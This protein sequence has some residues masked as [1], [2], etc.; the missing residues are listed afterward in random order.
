[1]ALCGNPTR[2]L[3]TRALGRKE[4][5]EWSIVDLACWRRLCWRGSSG[6][7]PSCDSEVLGRFRKSEAKSWIRLSALRYERVD[8]TRASSRPGIVYSLASASTRSPSSRRVSE[9]TGPMDTSFTPSSRLEWARSWPTRS[10]KFLAVEELVKC[11]RERLVRLSVGSVPTAFERI[12]EGRSRRLR[13][14]RPSL[15]VHAAR[16]GSPSRA[17]FARASRIRSP[18]RHL[19]LKRAHQG[20]CHVLLGHDVNRQPVKFNRFTSSRSDGSQF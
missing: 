13:Q 6:G 9:V 16:Q 8:S 2:P 18:V 19:V 15:R 4:R 20:L 11:D 10:T 3:S 7:V 5:R 12:R 1:M 14:H 17:T